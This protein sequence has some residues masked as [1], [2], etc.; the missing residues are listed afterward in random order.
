[1]VRSNNE[2][3]V[4][5]NSDNNSCDW[6]VNSHGCGVRGLTLKKIVVDLDDPKVLE[7]LADLEHKQW[8]HLIQ[9]LVAEGLLSLGKWKTSHYLNLSKI[10]YFDLTEGQK[11]SDRE[12][13]KRVL[14]VLEFHASTLK[15]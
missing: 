2:N 4:G 1:M 15:S 5:N 3:L 11:D 6:N 14:S 8:S 9:Y 10:D 7:R 13:A 12:W